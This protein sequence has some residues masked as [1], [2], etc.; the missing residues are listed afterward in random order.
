M[1]GRD[2]NITT[3]L[4]AAVLAQIGAVAFDNG[5]MMAAG[6]QS[7]YLPLGQQLHF[8]VQT[9]NNAVEQLPGVQVSG[10]GA[11]SISVNGSY[12][13]LNLH[14]TVDNNL[15]ASASLAGSQRDYNQPWAYLTQGQGVSVEVAGSAWNMNTIHFVQIDVDP[16]TNAWSVGGVA[17]GNTDA[18]RSAVASNWDPGFAATGGRGN[19][20]GTTGW[21]ASSGTGFYAPVLA[22]EGGDIFVIG[23]ANVDGQNHI[24]MFGQNVFGFE[25]LR[26]DQRSDFDYNDVV[27]KLTLA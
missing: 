20:G 16:A 3:D 2:G 22:T 6:I 19:F 11:L 21:T 13:T 12:G 25:D 14:A 8:A 17:Y 26:A 9:G 27:V 15:S 24:R 7:V 5:T 1:I 18:F 10:G 4:N 23:N